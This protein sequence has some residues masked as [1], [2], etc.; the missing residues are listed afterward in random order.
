[1]DYK[2]IR[3]TEMRAPSKL[4]NGSSAV[5][6]VTPRAPVLHPKMITI[7]ANLKGQEPRL[8]SKLQPNYRR[9]AGREKKP[10][11]FGQPQRREL[12]SFAQEHEFRTV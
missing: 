3:A 4:A 2:P 12:A 10:T 5:K 9:F 11:R 8:Q 7:Q 6:A 1:M